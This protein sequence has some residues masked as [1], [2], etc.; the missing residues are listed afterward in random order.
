MIINLLDIS[1][2]E[3]GIAGAVVGGMGL[4]IGILLGIAAKKLAVE[5]DERTEKVRACLAGSNCGGC[6]FAGCDACAEAIVKGEAPVN[7]CPGSDAA[8][9]AEVMGVEAVE[10]VKKVAFVKCVGTCDKTVVKYRYQGIPDCRKLALIPGHGEKECI[11]GC[12]GYGSCVN[13]CKFDAI[14]IESGVALVTPDRC[15]GC[16]MCT[17]VCPNGLIE[18]IP[19]SAKCAVAC[20]SKDKGKD[21]KAKCGAGCIGCGICAKQCENG[22]IT[23]ENN[24]AKIDF[25]KCTGCGKCAQKCPRKAISLI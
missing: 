13:A 10:T 22:A 8:K 4:I 19:Y 3:I 6:G 25:E 17:K 1:I 11:Y 15:T 14:S 21:T 12:M 18:L 24:L 16:G 9:I 23:V 7:A 2:K 5:A 20:F